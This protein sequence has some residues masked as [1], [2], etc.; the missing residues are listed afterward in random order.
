[1]DIFCFQWLL[2][3]A[4]LTCNVVLWLPSVLFDTVSWQEEEYMACRNLS[5]LA[6]KIF[7]RVSALV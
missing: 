1:M 6:K 7:Y 2:K 4:Y 5:Y 3:I